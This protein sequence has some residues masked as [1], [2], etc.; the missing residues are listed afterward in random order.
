MRW[1]TG[2]L[3][4]TIVASGV[5]LS[6]PPANAA[7]SAESYSKASAGAVPAYP[8]LKGQDADKIN[9]TPGYST[10]VIPNLQ[11][12]HGFQ[13]STDVEGTL[14]PGHTYSYCVRIFNRE[15]VDATYDLAPVDIRV[16]R[17]PDVVIELEKGKP[18]GTGAWIHFERTL[19]T[20]PSGT[21]ALVPY[22]IK[23]PAD[24]PPGTNFGGISID[25]HGAPGS[26]LMITKSIVVQVIV[27]IP[28]NAT[29]KLNVDDI[30]YQRLLVHPQDKSFVGFSVVADNQGNAIEHIAGD[31]TIK[32][33]TG[34]AVADLKLTPDRVLPKGRRRFRVM[35]ND[36]P[37][38]GY[39]RPTLNV[40]SDSG[41]RRIQLKGIIVIPPWKF[42]IALILAILLPIVVL[43]FR[44]WRRKVEWKQ[45]L[46]SGEFD[47]DESWDDADDGAE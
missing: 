18:I 12:S 21:I 34:H 22:V 25:E 41:V 28:G 42:T 10:T 3:A 45:Y 23:V 19:I 40:T 4:I 5:A 29:H 37:W 30:R 2:I 17:N 6:T 8:L 39:F 7:S 13:T 24:A 27:D 46:E 16:S 26:G 47:D 43:T 32:S 14:E 44:W 38:I 35:W 31:I 9:C 11:P 36:P 15:G 1:W 33:I 20:I